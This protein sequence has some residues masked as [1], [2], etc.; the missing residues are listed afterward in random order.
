VQIPMDWWIVAIEIVQHLNVDEDVGDDERREP[1]TS[2][3]AG[4]DEK[5]RTKMKRRERN[6]SYSETGTIERVIVDDVRSPMLRAF[7]CGKKTPTDNPNAKVRVG[8]E[9]TRSCTAIELCILSR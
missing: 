3:A 5:S 7:R 2:R 9:R 8:K 1:E 6:R 4:F